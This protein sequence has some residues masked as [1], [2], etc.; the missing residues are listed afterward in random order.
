MN[1]RSTVLLASSCS[2]NNSFYFLT[3]HCHTE[4]KNISVFHSWS[5]RFQTVT[6]H[7]QNVAAVSSLCTDTLCANN[8]MLVKLLSVIPFILTK[9]CPCFFFLLT[10]YSATS[11]YHPGKKNVKTSCTKF[12]NSKMKYFHQLQ[13]VFFVMSLS[14]ESTLHRKPAS[15]AKLQSF[16]TAVQH[17]LSHRQFPVLHSPASDRQPLHLLKIFL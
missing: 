6:P 10:P 12:A 8:I 15:T 2:F 4:G 11:K 14:M 3:T 5:W 1:R 13:G 17:I 9:G 7:T 16:S